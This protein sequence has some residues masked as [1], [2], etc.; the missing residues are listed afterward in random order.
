MT[1]LEAAPSL[2][3]E[4][5]TALGR[6]ATPL[7]FA[8]T[9]FVSAL[10][11]FTVQPMFTKMVLPRLGGAPSVW[12]VAMVAFQI[13]LFAGYAYA[14]LIARWLR[15]THAAALHLAI[16]AI[17]AS[18]LPLGIAS[19]FDVPPSDGVTALVDGAVC[20]LDRTSIRHVV[21]NSAI[22][23][24]LVRRQRTPA[25]EKSLCP[26]CRI[27]SRLLR[28]AAGLSVRDRALLYV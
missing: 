13:F 25:S 21:R 27:Q 10:L 14:H 23:A 7:L 16:V 24:I 5:T 4:D 9:L 3:D 20:L 6:R 22:A 12:S 2:R 15:P 11:L 17:V 18:M 1:S 8:A 19:G 26:L 28:G